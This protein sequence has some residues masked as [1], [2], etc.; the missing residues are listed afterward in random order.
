MNLGPVFIIFGVLENF[1]WISIEFTSIWVFSKWFNQIQLNLKTQQRFLTW[2]H[3]LE[4]KSFSSQVWTNL[5]WIHLNWIWFEIYLNNT[6]KI[7]KIH[8]SLGP[9][10]SPRPQCIL[11]RGLVSWPRPAAFGSPRQQGS[12]HL[13]QHSSSYPPLHRNLNR[14]GRK[15]VLTRAAMVRWR[16]LVSSG[17]AAP[18]MDKSSRAWFLSCTRKPQALEVWE[19][20]LPAT[21]SSGTSSHRR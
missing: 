10:C 17:Q 2:I 19:G 13:P 3:K 5:G 21:G 11:G 6:K 15:G 12:R 8:Y 20:S 9:H 4:S 14:D 7:E 16:R 18:N 1:L